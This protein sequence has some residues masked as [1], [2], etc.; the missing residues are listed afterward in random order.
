MQKG[1]ECMH[2]HRAHAGHVRPYVRR[3]HAGYVWLAN[4]GAQ[5]A[6]RRGLHAIRAGRC[7]EY[8]AYRM[9]GS[10]IQLLRCGIQAHIGNRGIRR[11]EALYRLVGSI[12]KL[13]SG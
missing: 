13:F 6:T 3:A 11:N 4:V 5:P 12:G 10:N 1:I 8:F 9:R 2:L 7:Y